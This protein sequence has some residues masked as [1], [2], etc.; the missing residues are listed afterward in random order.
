M[1]G[2]YETDKESGGLM[3]DVIRSMKKIALLRTE[4]GISNEKILTQFKGLAVL[5]SK[6]LNECKMAALGDDRH[7]NDPDNG[8]IG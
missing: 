3:Y 4:V 6:K 2:Y 1:L 7:Y 8:V 5:L